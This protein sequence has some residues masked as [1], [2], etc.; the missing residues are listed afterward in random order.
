MNSDQVFYYIHVTIINLYSFRPSH[1][2]AITQRLYDV[3]NFLDLPYDCW[4][5]SEKCTFLFEVVDVTAIK[6]FLWGPRA[7]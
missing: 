6:T 4:N 1:Q 7:V 5:N 2:V 3:V